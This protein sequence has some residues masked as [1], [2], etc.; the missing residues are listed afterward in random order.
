MTD[1]LSRLHAARPTES[2]LESL[3]SDDDRAALLVRI[4]TADPARPSR[5][6]YAA[7]VGIVAAATTALLVVPATVDPPSAAAADLRALA[8]TAASYGGPVLQEGTWLH[9]RATSVQRNSSTLGDGAVYSRERETWTRWDGRTLLVE[10]DPTAGWTTYDVIDGSH[11]ITDL[12]APAFHD[13]ASYQD[14]TPQF[15]ATLPRTAEGLLA[16]L[17]GRVFGSSSH[18][19]ALYSALVE[20]GDVSHACARRARCHVRRPRDGRR[21]PHRR[22]PGGGTTGGGGRLRRRRD[23]ER[24]CDGRRRGNRAGAVGT[25]RQQPEHLHLHHDAQRGGVRDPRGSRRSRRAAPGGRSV[26]G[27]GRGVARL[28]GRAAEHV[29]RWPPTYLVGRSPITGAD[30]G[31]SATA[32]SGPWSRRPGRRPTRAPRRGVRA[33]AR[34]LPT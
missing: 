17:D 10:S 32:G 2:E 7:A 33:R 12:E 16:Y 28:N 27:V 26:R 1:L 9:Q 21:R 15:A 29:G 24:R 3:W 13:R 8:R 19:E 18:D 11:A 23:G 4:E 14:P 25:Q 20:P 22:R 34:Q 30:S 6:R 31:T 5:Y